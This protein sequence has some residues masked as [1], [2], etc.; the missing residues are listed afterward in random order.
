MLKVSDQTI[1]Q[2]TVILPYF[3][4]EVPVLCLGEGAHYISVT[5]LCKMPGMRV[6]YW[7]HA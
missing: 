2:T 7:Q 4:S 6:I 1:Q 3:D 5:M